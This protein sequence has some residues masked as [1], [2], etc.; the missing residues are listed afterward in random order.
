MFGLF[1]ILLFKLQ[2]HSDT[3]GLIDQKGGIVLD[4]YL[5]YCQHLIFKLENFRYILIQAAF[6]KLLEIFDTNFADA[7]LLYFH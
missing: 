4:S 3:K 2:S 5:F 7:S 1:V 6:G